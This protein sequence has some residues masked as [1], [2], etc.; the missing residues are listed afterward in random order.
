M[1]SRRRRRFLAGLL[2]AS[3]IGAA[4][5]IAFWFNLLSGIQLQG[6]D[7]LFKAA[8]VYRSSGLEGR[9]VIIGID[10]K[11]LDQLGHLPLWPRSYHA[12]LIDVLNEAEARVVVFDILFSE[13]APG[14]EQ[15][16]EAIKDSGNVILPI[17]YAAA[18]NEST[19]VGESMEPGSFVRSLSIFEE[20]AVAVGHANV[21]PDEDGVVRRLPLAIRNG[22]VY[23]PALALAAVAE[24]LR[25]P[26]AIESPIENNRLAFAGRSIPL[27][28]ANGMLINYVAG[29]ADAGASAGFQTVSYVD[30]LRGEVDPATFQDKTVV[31]GATASGLGDISWTPTGRVMNGVEIHANAIRT[32]L[33]GDFLRS[34]PSSVNIAVIMVLA[35]L[36]G[37]L[38]LR[39]R[40]LWA[41]LSAFFI[42]LV[43]FLTAF[44]MFDKGIMLSMVY[45]PLA[46]LGTFVGVNLFNI[47]S[48]RTEKREITKTFGR[49]VS[50]SV[51]ERILKALEQGELNLEG[52]QQEVTVVFADV[53]GYTGM[54]EKMQPEELVRVLNIYLSVVIKEVLRHKGMINKFGGDSVMAIWNVPTRCEG[55]AL[56]ATKAAVDAQRAIRELQQNDASLPK[57]DFGI[58]INTGKAV[59][60]NLGSEDRLEYS[61]VGAVVNIAARLTSLAESG[62][63][64]IGSDTYDLIGD[65]CVTKPLGTLELRGKQEPIRAYEVVDIRQES[66]DLA[67]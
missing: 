40:V 20:G 54:S 66:V 15:L 19:G 48:E 29:S 7:F 58:G 46:I 51:V 8:S 50:P 12:H 35:L 30:T 16:A 21:L 32:I 53:R 9:V 4:F 14:D 43:Y 45:P 18:R 62:K 42:C 10:E 52:Q 22:A 3:C 49:Y 60:G 67:C 6:S 33:T 39:L 59:A 61:V 41:T 44:S 64:W 55:H 28:D 56:L 27:D 65:Y 11:S 31:V 23:E 5:C 25:R 37:L 38:V 47:T 34:V 17:V 26:Q 57:V 63:V 1:R 13:P 36:C 2:I 24:Y